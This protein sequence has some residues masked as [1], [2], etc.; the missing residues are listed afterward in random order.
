MHVLLLLFF[1]RRCIVQ[2]LGMLFILSVLVTLI[3][4]LIPLLFWF[5][6]GSSEHFHSQNKPVLITGISQE[7]IGHSLAKIVANTS[8]S[9]ILVHYNATG[10][11]QIVKD[12]ANAGCS[13]I[14]H[15]QVDLKDTTQTSE[16]LATIPKDLHLAVLLHTVST[17]GDC[18][19]VSLDHYRTNL[20]VNFLS[21]INL[22]QQ[23]VP[24]LKKN[25]GKLIV[26]SSVAG[27]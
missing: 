20:E 22:A 5:F 23:L 11:D 7:N 6:K 17:Y 14:T 12:C 4:V 24:V 21:Y 15:Y 27:K 25:D 3:V 13:N 8:S 1:T 9:L 18:L 2:R 26:S 19:S 10:I 16:F